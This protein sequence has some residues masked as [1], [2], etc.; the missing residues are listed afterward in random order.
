MEPFRT[1]HFAHGSAADS[2][3]RATSGTSQKDAGRALVRVGAL[4]ETDNCESTAPRNV[5]LGYGAFSRRRSMGSKCKYVEN[6]RYCDPGPRWQERQASSGS[7][8][9]GVRWR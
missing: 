4:D 1:T 2:R 5:L 3:R 9:F 6:H 8:S 7:A